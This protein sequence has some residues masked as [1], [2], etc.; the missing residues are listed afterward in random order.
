[1]PIWR[2]LAA[3][4]DVPFKVFYLSDQG[5]KGSFDPGFGRAIAWDIDLLTG[6]PH[7]FVSTTVGPRQDRF[8]WL[9]LDPDFIA[10]LREEGFTTLWLQGWQVRAYWQA[11]A[12][13]RRAG[14]KVWLRGESNLR[15]NRGGLTQR[16]KWIA[17]RRFLNK[18]DRFLTIGKA[19]RAFYRRLGYPEE[20]MI[21]APYC[22]ENRRFEQQAR[23]ALPDRSELRRAWKIPDD[24][25]CFLWVGKF[26]PKK[27]P[28]D[29]AAAARLLQRSMPGKRVHLLWVG[30]GELQ[31]ELEA[32]CNREGLPT[33][34]FAGF[35]NQSEIARA[36]VAADALVLPSDAKETWGLVVNEAMA[37]G[38]PCVVSDACGCSDDLVIPFRPDLCFPVGDVEALADA[39]ARVIENPPSADAVRAQVANCDV[40]R[41]IEAAAT[42]YRSAA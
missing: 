25:F 8:D 15:S 5:L 1:V 12:Q 26:I 17:L 21:A 22:V 19:N 28:L 23:E 42:L 6:Y 41:T 36:Y 7:E 35:L 31:A 3:R 10:R 27:R 30:T 2:G 4:G 9:S 11:V 18:V 34:T 20:R 24:A 39:M 33:A 13:A 16:L 38:L 32:A 37:S 40:S 14:M 29:L